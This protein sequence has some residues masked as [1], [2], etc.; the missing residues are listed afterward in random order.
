MSRS[1]KPSL[2]RWRRD[3]EPVVVPSQAIGTA[4]PSQEACADMAKRLAIKLGRPVVIAFPNCVA[5]G[6]PV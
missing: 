2:R 4:T 1:L 3:L 5:F 6:Y